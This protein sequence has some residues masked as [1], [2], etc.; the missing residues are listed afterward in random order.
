MNTKLTIICCIYNE[1]NILKKKFNILSEQLK[2]HSFYHEIIFVDNN[3]FDGS[4]EYLIKNK[5]K[6]KKSK[7]IFNKNNIQKGGSIKR[8]LKM[9]SG[10]IAV[11]FDIDEYRYSDIKKGYEKFIKS[12]CSFLIGS[13]LLRPNNKFV[14]RLNFYG[15]I[16]LT[17]LINLLY[18]L[19]LTDSASGTKFF[20]TENKNLLNV[21][22]NGFDY[23]FDLLI[24]FAKQKKNIEEYAINYTPRTIKE[25]KK[26][27]PI[28]DGLKILKIIITKI[29]K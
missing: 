19:K 9:S 18:K 25:G 5:N 21:N 15:V 8:A 12:N 3:S 20:S 28:Q 27:K 17:K 13:R 10:G 1:L 23:E 24:N 14:Y 16:L 29:F 6:I 26:I 7:F 4:K 2:K 22:S 11:I